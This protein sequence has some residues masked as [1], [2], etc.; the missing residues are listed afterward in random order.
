MADIFDEVSEELKQDQ[1]IQ[2]WKKYS[3]HIFILLILLILSISSYQGY[4]IWNKKQLTKNSEEFFS[5]L[6]KLEIE[7]FEESSDI[8]YN[9]SIQQKDGYRILSIFGLAHS[10]FKIGRISEMVENYQLIYDDKDVGTYYKYLARMLSVMKDNKSSLEKLVDRL[11]PILNSPSKLQLL[12][13]ELEMILYFKFNKTEKGLAA[14]ET[15]L[16]RSDITLEQ[17][18]R[19]N[20]IKKVYNSHEK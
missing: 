2:I 5:G 17:K 18:N 15:L 13:A 10:N 3:K 19:V 9:N 1:L 6:E 8:F 14:I 12:A 7:K 4:L 11:N 16:T 20:L